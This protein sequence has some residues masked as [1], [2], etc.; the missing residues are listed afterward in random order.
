M[1]GEAVSESFS[2]SYGTC[3]G[4]GKTGELV[5]GVCRH[6]RRVSRAAKLGCFR[7]AATRDPELLAHYVE[8][9]KQRPRTPTEHIIFHRMNAVDQKG[10]GCFKYVGDLAIGKL[11][12]ET[13]VDPR[14][15]K[16]SPRTARRA[17]S[18]LRTRQEILFAGQTKFGSNCYLFPNKK[19]QGSN[20]P[21][22]ETRAVHHLWSVEPAQAVITGETKRPVSVIIDGYFVNRRVLS[23]W[24]PNHIR[25]AIATIKLWY[26]NDLS[27]IDE[28]TSLLKTVLHMH[29]AGRDLVYAAKRSEE[30]KAKDQKRLRQV[31]QDLKLRANRPGEDK[32]EALKVL[33]EL[34]KLLGGERA[35][36]RAEGILGVRGQVATPQFAPDTE[37]P[38]PAPPPVGRI[39][40]TT[41][42]DVVE[43]RPSKYSIRWQIEEFLKPHSVGNKETASYYGFKN[44]NLLLYFPV[45][46]HPEALTADHVIAYGRL[47]RSHITQRNLPVSDSTIRKELDLLYSALQIKDPKLLKVRRMFKPDSTRPPRWLEFEE[48]ERIRAELPAERRQWLDIAIY[49]GCRLGELESLL[50]EHVDLKKR[51]I[52]IPGKK[53]KKSKR[54]IPAHDEVIRVAEERIAAGYEKGPLVE[55]WSNCWR[56]LGLV[57]DKVGILRFSAL[58]LRHTFVTWLLSKE[59]TSDQIKELTG[60][61]DTDMIDRVYG[62]FSDKTLRRVI[63]A[64]PHIS[65]RAGPADHPPPA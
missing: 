7:R 56:D 19:Y 63:D 31:E 8:F 59:Q 35:A 22:C 60:H 58:D 12:K 41:P 14:E 21:I 20:L 24:Q 51:R 53:T 6:S 55:S 50:I 17:I 57:C 37:L 48:Y 52:F 40:P 4:C 54:W 16:V 62:H 23:E 32:E 15:P 44:R 1:Q 33:G 26:R 18:G 13:P 30:A 27:R 5:M 64:L 38:T 43:K 2:Q 47:R 34:S 9:Q 46:L 11:A 3:A 65:K 28:Q 45:D 10:M 25:E 29:L 36:E 39:S 42:Q 61:T 49:T